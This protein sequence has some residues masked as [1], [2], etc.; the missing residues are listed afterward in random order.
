MRLEIDKSFVTVTNPSERLLLVAEAL[1]LGLDTTREFSVLERV[2]IQSISGQTPQLLEKI[3][4]T[5]SVLPY[6]EPA[7]ASG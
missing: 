4:C 2:E 3:F 7:R 6:P 1:G 5:H